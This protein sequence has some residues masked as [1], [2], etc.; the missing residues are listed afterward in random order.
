MTS[1]ASDSPRTL[2]ERLTPR[3]NT[4]VQLYGAAIV[5]T[6][7]ASILIFRGVDY[8]HDRYWHAWALAAALAIAVVK[9][10]FLLDRIAR[11]AVDGSRPRDRASGSSRQGLGF[12]AG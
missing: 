5:W 2:L 9:S 3:A 4:R 6:V 1:P 11:K 8:V 7:G 12:G 10:R